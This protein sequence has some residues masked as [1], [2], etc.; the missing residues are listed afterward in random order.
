[1]H[2]RQSVLGHISTASGRHLT[3]VDVGSLVRRLILFDKVVARSFRLKEV[4]LLVRTF[5]VDGLS[6]LLESGLL[7]FSCGVTTVILDSSQ[8]GVRHLPLNHFCLATG[9]LDNLDA[10]LLS[11]LCA[12][13][14]ISGLKNERRAALEDVIWRSLS[15]EPATYGQDL[16]DQIDR[17]F[18]AGTPALKVALIDAVRRELSGRDVAESEVTVS[19]EETS[20][21][22]FHIRNSLPESFGFS[23]EQTHLLLQRAVGAVANLDQRLADM[24]AHSSIA[25]F[26]ES[27]APMLFG[28]LAGIIAPMNPKAAEDHFERVIE[29]AD[30]PDFKTGQKVNVELLIKVRDSAECREFREWLGTLDNVT[31]AAIKEMVAGVKSRIASLA[32]S[33]PGKVMRF[34]TTTGLGLIPVVGPVMGAVAGA[35]DSFLVDRVLPRSGL[36]AFLTQTYPSLFV[37]P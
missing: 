2:V 15:K 31:D 20:N 6:H 27:E 36:V 7:S 16:R 35:I 4:P 10:T 37:S 23:A 1:M 9:H 22:V 29:L 32:S 8:N 12:L 14:S 34:A 13:Q 24:Q 19:V 28:K 33:T 18:R 5:G 30:V 21:R 3:S 25:G 11:E 26:L 17:D